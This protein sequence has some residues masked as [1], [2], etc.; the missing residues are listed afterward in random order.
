MR[1]QRFLVAI[2]IV[3]LAG[4][5]R[6]SELKPEAGKSLP[7]KPLLARQTPT[8]EQL[9]A[10]DPQAKPTRVDELMKRSQPRKADRFDLPP[11]DAGLAPAPP[12][13]ATEP[14][15]STT[16]PDTVEEPQ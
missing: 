4:C 13:T 7:V 16:G 8:P 9:L 1:L 15:P 10:L 11:P 12:A 2:A 6:V 5:G 3:A 14:Q